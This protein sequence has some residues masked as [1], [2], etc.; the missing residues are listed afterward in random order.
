[1]EQ[2][3]GNAGSETHFCDYRYIVG[4]CKIIV[5]RVNIRTGNLGS[6]CSHTILAPKFL[7]CLV[8]R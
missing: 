4:R 6:S 5:D 3:F 1:M 2:F 7:E 8:L